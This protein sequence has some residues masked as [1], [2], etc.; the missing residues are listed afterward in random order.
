MNAK[1]RSRSRS[2]PLVAANTAEAEATQRVRAAMAPAAAPASRF[3]EK[4]AQELICDLVRKKQTDRAAKALIDMLP[5]MF[6]S[7]VNIKEKMNNLLFLSRVIQ[8]GGGSKYGHVKL[9]SKI[10]TLAGFVGDL[11]LP[12]GGF[13]EFGCGAH[14]PIS[15]SVFF[16]LNGLAPACGVDLLGPRAEYFSALSM[17]DILAH[18]KMFPGRYTWA[19]RKPFEVLSQLREINAV[20][21]ERGDFWGGLDSLDGKVRLINDDLV[22]CDLAPGS[23]ALLTSFAVLEHVTDLAGIMRRCFE[24]SVPGG[25]NY[26]F[27]DLADHRSYRGDGEF[28]PLSFLTEPVAPANMNRLRAPQFAEAARAAGFEV[29]RDQRIAT[30]FDDELRA[31]FVPPFD[32]MPIED[33]AV[34]KQHLVLRKPD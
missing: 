33:V 14:D 34:I 3:S 2:A 18:V 4:A 12:A 21:F 13:V 10:K 15:M 31:K 28:G 5:Q 25:I 26:H 29:L 9:R 19:G 8:D 24:L 22:Q 23:I 17:F 1:T 27:I 7:N 6:E 30:A 32:A 16:Y 20:L 11:P